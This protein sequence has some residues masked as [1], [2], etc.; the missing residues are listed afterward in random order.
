MYQTVIPDNYL[1]II[2]LLPII[3]FFILNIAKNINR[4]I[5]INKNEKK[6]FIN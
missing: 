1:L 3:I 6:T 4:M 2:K 5:N